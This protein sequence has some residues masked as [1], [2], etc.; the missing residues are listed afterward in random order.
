[1]GQTILMVNTAKWY[2]VYCSRTFVCFS[3][4]F[5]KCNMTNQQKIIMKWTIMEIFLLLDPQSNLLLK[6]PLYKDTQVMGWWCQGMQEIWHLKKCIDWIEIDWSSFSVSYHSMFS[7]Q[8]K[9]KNKK[10]PVHLHSK[11]KKRRVF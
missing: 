8:F 3:E 7:M 6:C 1:M 2:Q 4:L 9:N 10:Q 5:L 11:W